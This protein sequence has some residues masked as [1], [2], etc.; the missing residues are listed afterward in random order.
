MNL[1]SSLKRITDVSFDHVK[2]NSDKSG[3]FLKITGQIEDLSGSPGM[4]VGKDLV[5]G[6]KA[7]VLQGFRG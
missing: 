7:P 4:N 1:R 3:N 5:L 2:P 6:L